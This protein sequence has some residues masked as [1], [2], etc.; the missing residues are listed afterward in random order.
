MAKGNGGGHAGFSAGS[1]WAGWLGGPDG[2]RAR[3]LVAQA[4][5]TALILVRRLARKQ[6]IK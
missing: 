2:W 6:N 4:P 1:G 3:A 5:I